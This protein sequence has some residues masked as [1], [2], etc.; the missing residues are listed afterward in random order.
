MNFPFQVFFYL[1]AAVLFVAIRLMQ[2][3]S[4]QTCAMELGVKVCSGKYYLYA[5]LICFGTLFLAYCLTIL[6]PIDKLLLLETD[7]KNYSFDNDLLAQ[8]VSVFFL[9]LVGTAAGEE[10]VFRGMLGGILFRKLPFYVA[11]GVQTVFFVLPHS[12]LLLVSVRFAP[13]LIISAVVGWLLGYLRFQSKSIFP[14]ILTH[15]VMNTV[16]ILAFQL[17]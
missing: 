3:A 12:L 5:A 6:F 11:N 2:K 13:Y 16:A 4:L 14:G 17:I 15:A 9:Q 7:Y 1:F 8:I 10:L